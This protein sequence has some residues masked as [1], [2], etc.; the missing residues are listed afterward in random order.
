[1]IFNFRFAQFGFQFILALFLVFIQGSLSHADDEIKFESFDIPTAF[2][3]S[4]SNDSNRVDYGLRLNKDCHPKDPSEPVFYYWREFEP[5][6]PVRTHEV[7]WM[8]KIGYGISDQKTL[9]VTNDGAEISMVL[10]QVDKP[11]KIK[12][13]KNP[14]AGP[15]NTAPCSSTVTT[16]IAGVPDALMQSVF[17]KVSGP[18][19]IDYIDIHGIH[20]KTHLPIEERIK[21]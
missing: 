5:P 11:I 12:V 19:S 1:M 18:I 21:N 14:D 2:F 15:K 4:K 10:K 3:I 17:V 20:P 6:P 8:D 16:A 13:F 7:N 9:R